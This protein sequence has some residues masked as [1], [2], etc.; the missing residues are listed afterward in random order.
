MAFQSININAEL[1]RV[2]SYVEFANFTAFFDLLK[3]SGGILPTSFKNSII[4]YLVGLLVCFPLNLLFAY[5]IFSKMFLHK[6]LRIVIMIPQ[7]VST[8][9]V[10]LLFRR[11]IDY[12]GALPALLNIIMPNNN[13]PTNVLMDP[14]TSFG[15]ILFYMIWVSFS[16]SVIVYQNAMKEISDEILESASL[17]GVD[18]MFQELRYIIL[19]LIYP[20]I[21]TFLITGFAGML[22]MAGPLVEFYMYDAP[23]EVYTMGYYYLRQTMI[24]PESNYPVLAAGGL[25]MTVLVA[26]LTFVLKYFL[27]KA[28]PIKDGY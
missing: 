17:D 1:G 8:F 13:F 27:E 5:I 22:I 26:P 11:F 14:A 10:S 24:A 20:T 7:V 4:I 9:V 23:P 12:N 2:T 15:T 6:G 25:L 18:G 19:P 16:T 3:V 21:T 28:S